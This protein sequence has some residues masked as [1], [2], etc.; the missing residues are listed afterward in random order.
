M[1]LR[2]LISNAIKFTHSGGQVTISS[3]EVNG[4]VEIRVSDNGIGIADNEIEKLFRIDVKVSNRGTANER[5]TGLGLILCKE[6]VERSGGK[7]WVESQL[8]KGSN[9]IFTLP[10]SAEG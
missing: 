1:V 9:F 2:N 6:F 10:T 8:E 5:G 3:L 4:F 7:I